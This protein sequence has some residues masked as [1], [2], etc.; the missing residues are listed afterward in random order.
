M[1]NTKTETITFKTFRVPKENETLHAT[2]VI[3]DTQNN[4]I[5]VWPREQMEGGYEPLGP[6]GFYEKG[7]Y[8]CGVT[9]RQYDEV[10]AILESSKKLPYTDPGTS[11]HEVTPGFLSHFCEK[12]KDGKHR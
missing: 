1:A 2:R 7:T 9:P 11:K 8:K 4:M 3:S 6:I 12:H 10:L 5:A